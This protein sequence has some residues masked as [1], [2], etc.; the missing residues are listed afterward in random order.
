[1]L[2]LWEF[3]GVWHEGSVP[4]FLEGADSLF[5]PSGAALW[6]VCVRPCGERD[7]RELPCYGWSC[8]GREQEADVTAV[9]N[10]PRWQRGEAEPQA[11]GRGVCCFC[12]A[13]KL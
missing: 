11:V 6:G 3:D 12:R 8:V 5:Q 7:K 4:A 9:S 13:R 2:F 1:M 10:P